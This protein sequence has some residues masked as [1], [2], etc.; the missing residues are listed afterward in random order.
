MDAESPTDVYLVCSFS[1]RTKEHKEFG[2]F[3][4]L[5]F[6]SFPFFSYPFRSVIKDPDIALLSWPLGRISVQ[7]SFSDYRPGHLGDWKLELF[8]M[9]LTVN[10]IS[11]ALYLSGNSIVMRID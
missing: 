11:G 7:N 4:F 3:Q 2:F 10:V 5:L 8:M 6:F 1:N 9:S